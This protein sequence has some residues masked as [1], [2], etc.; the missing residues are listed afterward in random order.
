M[1]I[2][3]SSPLTREGKIDLPLQGSGRRAYQSALQIFADN[4][5]EDR[6]VRLAD[7]LAAFELT[8]GISCITPLQAREDA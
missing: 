8:D 7:G 6:L 2:S 4:G 3:Q 1:L 5:L